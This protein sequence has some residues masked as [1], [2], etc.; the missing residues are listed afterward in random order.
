MDASSTEQPLDQ[1]LEVMKNLQGP[2]YQC[3]KQ[4][5]TQLVKQGQWPAE[6]LIPSEMALVVA[7]GVSRM[8][9]NR[10]MRELTVEGVLQRQQGV[11]TFVAARKPLQLGLA[12]EDIADQITQSGAQHSLQVLRQTQAGAT[13][14][15]A[16]QM[17]VAVGTPLFRGVFIH[18]A[19]DKPVQL[20]E[21]LLN[22]E[23]V[24]DFAQQ[25][26]SHITP[27]QFMRQQ[28]AVERVEK[29]VEAVLP[30]R[31]EA[32]LFGFGENKPC[33]QMHRTVW[34]ENQIVSQV[35][36]LTPDLILQLEGVR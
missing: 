21:R 2:V 4:A 31:W 23:L 13:S 12:V 6:M 25:D 36:L 16:K 29:W 35:R 32:Q 3:L 34:A 28:Q 7:L 8:T 27:Y 20:E 24:P 19:D 33:L 18:F 14:D 30:Q 1:L 9:V 15:E 10:A 17:A 26:F 11:G 5:I 22:V